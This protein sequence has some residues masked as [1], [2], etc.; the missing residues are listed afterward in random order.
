MKRGVKMGE[1]KI[2]QITAVC[3]VRVMDPNLLERVVRVLAALGAN[4]PL[5]T[6]IKGETRTGGN[7]EQA[8]AFLRGDDS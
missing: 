2:V 4:D 5:I 6:L 7:V 1:E 8:L 3:Q